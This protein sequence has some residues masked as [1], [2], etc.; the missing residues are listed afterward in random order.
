MWQHHPGIFLPFALS[1]AGLC[2][3]PV[4]Y[5]CCILAL[6]SF[7][8]GPTFSLNYYTLAFNAK[9][10]HSFFFFLF[11]D[12]FG[13]HLVGV[14][15]PTH[16]SVPGLLWY[17]SHGRG[18]QTKITSHFRRLPTSLVSPTIP[19]WTSDVGL[20]SCDKKLSSKKMRDEELIKKT[21]FPL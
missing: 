10:S 5:P 16:K 20:F 8:D 18:F 19:L 6:V 21:A 3:Q 13:V 1:K 7:K 15:I 11:F 9:G 12:F 2:P 17:H 14:L 4:W